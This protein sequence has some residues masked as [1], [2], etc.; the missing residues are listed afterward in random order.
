MDRVPTGPMRSV[1]ARLVDP[2]PMV[3]SAGD[4]R[5]SR[6]LALMLLTG[7]VLASFAIIGW[8]V[9]PGRHVANIEALTSAMSALVFGGAYVLARYGRNRQAIWLAVVQSS[10]AVFVLQYAALEGLNPLYQATDGAELMFLALP[11]LL[12]GTFLPWK[13][14]LGVGGALLSFMLAIPSVTGHISYAELI[15][16]PVML[17]LT[18]TVLTATAGAHRERLE[19]ERSAELRTEIEERRKAE[20]ELARHRDEL[21]RL[22]HERTENLEIA[23]RQLVEANEA[24]SRFLANMSH[25]LRTPLNSI[26][27]FTGVM[28]QGMAGPLSDEQERQLKMVD[29]SSRQLLGLINQVLDLARIESG[30]ET[31][32]RDTFDVV[33]LLAEVVDVIEPLAASKD[34]SVAIDGVD[35]GGLASITTD[36]GKLRQILLNLA[37]N[38]VKFTDSGGV[39]LSAYEL[40]DTLVVVTVADTGIGIAPENHHAVFDEYRQI[41]GTREAKPQGTG[42]GLTVSRRLARLLGGDIEVASALGAGSRFSVVIAKDPAPA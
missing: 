6:L 14:V 20:T 31:V 22:V 35:L 13:Q 3:R 33:G 21:E 37:G 39:T 17:V 26:I 16:G 42:L 9:S 27:G 38:A 11:M 10:L 32:E 1:L 2:V 40:G 36:R 30:L 41:S 15:P 29:R 18:A 8:A 25:E 7:I 34:L 19:A 12:A 23:M 5:T 4:R 28:R 24:K